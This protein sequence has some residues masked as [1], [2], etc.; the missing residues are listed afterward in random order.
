MYVHA[1][2]RR[3]MFLTALFIT[4]KGV[5][6]IQILSISKWTNAVYTYSRTLFSK[7]RQLHLLNVGEPQKHV[8]WKKLGAKYY[9][10][11]FPFY[12][13]KLEREMME[14]EYIS[15]CLTAGGGRNEEWLLIGIKFSL[16]W[17]KYYRIRY[18]EDCTTL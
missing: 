11:W 15:G 1:K 16:W 13:K 6:A 4:A 3:R 7:I 9:F 18:D 14:T 2:T 8:R 17:W 12:M 10:V 5:G